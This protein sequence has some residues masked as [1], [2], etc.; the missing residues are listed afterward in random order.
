MVLESK[1]D[2]KESNV[3]DELEKMRTL[4][5]SRFCRSIFEADLILMLIF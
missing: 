3:N 4:A 1:S 2:P 5:S